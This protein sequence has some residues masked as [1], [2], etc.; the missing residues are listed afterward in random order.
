M[1]RGLA[2]RR[3]VRRRARKDFSRAYFSACRRVVN[4]HVRTHGQM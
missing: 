4:A 1:Q 2:R 3:A